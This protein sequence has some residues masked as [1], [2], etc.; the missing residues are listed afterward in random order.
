MCLELADARIA[1]LSVLKGGRFPAQHSANAY[2]DLHM[3]YQSEHGAGGQ[4]V[5]R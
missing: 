2:H 4:G 3:N 5:E 1:Q